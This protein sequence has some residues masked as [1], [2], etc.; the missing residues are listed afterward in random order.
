ML[1][2]CCKCEL[3]SGKQSLKT[4]AK[5][6]MKNKLAIMSGVLATF[7]IFTSS[8]QAIPITGSIIIAGLD[9]GNVLTPVGSK[10]GTATGIAATTGTVTYG[11]G[12]YTGTA[13]ASVNIS[14]F[15]LN[16]LSTTVSPLWS[17]MVGG[18][19]YSFDL[20]GMSVKISGGLLSITGTGML[21]IAGSGSSYDETGGTWTYFAVDVGANKFS[22]GVFGFLS[23]NTAVSDPDLTPNTPVGSVPDGGMTI[24]LLGVALS[25]L[26]FFRKHILV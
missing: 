12:S 8:V 1:N 22:D 15:M 26:Y 6:K 10:L 24:I 3:E 2:V 19:T 21:S 16:P 9:G 5:L 25:C 11:D 7:V 4:L 18:L 14:S 20:T 17:F 13:G 23:S